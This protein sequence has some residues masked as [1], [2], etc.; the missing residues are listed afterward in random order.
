[1]DFSALD[2]RGA[3]EVGAFLHLRN[4]WTGELL[5]NAKGEKSGVMVRGT[6]SNTVQ[7]T[8]QQLAKNLKQG[9]DT[10]RGFAFVSSLVFEFVNV[11]YKGRALENTEADKKL[12]FGLSDGFVE[13]VVEFAKERGSFFGA[14]SAD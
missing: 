3:A 6:E 8:L 2:T 11:E 12:F 7:K 10:Q 9:D 1:M 14:K 13:Q 4:P 5:Y